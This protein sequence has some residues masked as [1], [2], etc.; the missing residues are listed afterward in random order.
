MVDPVST[1]S[2]AK[3]VLEELNK[4]GPLSNKLE[5]YWYEKGKLKTASIVS[6]GLK[7]LVKLDDEKSNDSI[8]SIWDDEDKNKLKDKDSNNLK[9]LKRYV[10]FATEK[11]RDILIAFKSQIGQER[12]ITDRNN[13]DAIL[14][15]TTINGI[16]NT[17]RLIIENNKISNN[18]SYR[19]SL[20]NI[21]DFEFKDYK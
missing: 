7:P 17:L 3:K 10:D 8:Y 20:E 2:I 6:Y 18:D 5:E 15:V 16:F 1:I 12:W 4:S 13:P 19:K 21:K 9:L 11:I 14:T